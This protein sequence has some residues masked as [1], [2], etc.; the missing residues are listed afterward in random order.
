MTTRE[1]QTQQ[2]RRIYAH[3]LRRAQGAR[4]HGDMTGAAIAEAQAAGA[5]ARILDTFTVR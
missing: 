1:K 4:H 2:D 3:A 5:L